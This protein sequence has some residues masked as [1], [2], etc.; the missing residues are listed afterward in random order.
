MLQLYTQ[1]GFYKEELISLVKKGID[2]AEQIKKMMISL[3]ENPL[4]EINGEKVVLVEDYQSS[5]S[6]NYGLTETE[7]N[8]LDVPKSNVLIYYTEEGTKVAARPSGTEP[9]IKFYI[10]VNA[11]LDKVENHEQVAQ[12]LSEKGS[13]IR[14]ELDLG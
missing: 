14:A 11:P 10:S 8:T 6:F 1:Y 4:S 3:R 12:E 2:G 5:Q 7:V 13:A 9:K